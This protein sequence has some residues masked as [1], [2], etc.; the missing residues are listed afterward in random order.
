[1]ADN[2][3]LNIGSGGDTVRTLAKAINSP[4]K[5]QVIS[6]DVGGGD[7]S[8][9]SLLVLGQ[10]VKASSL[11]VTIASDQ[12]SIDISATSLP[13]P[14]GA[15]I[16]SLQP[17]IN[18]DGGSL[19]HITN[20]PVSQTAQAIKDSSGS[21]IIS[22]ASQVALAAGSVTRYLFIQNPGYYSNGT[23]ITNPLFL[24]FG[25]NVASFTSIVLVPGESFVMEVGVVSSDQINL[26]AADAG[27]PYII[28]YF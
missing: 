25:T 1:M 10:N 26:M 16:S 13:L 11:P 9:E 7:N 6:L 8:P 23:I 4:A 22:N 2:T 17:A 20:F 28:K 27:H 14:T 15:A 5:T 24:N 12:N 3:T 18:A 19:A 21:I